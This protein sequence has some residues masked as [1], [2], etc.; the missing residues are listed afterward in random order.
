MLD[1]VEVEKRRSGVS[2]KKAYRPTG[3][4]LGLLQGAQRE[5]TN[6]MAPE[7]RGD[8]HPTRRRATPEKK[9]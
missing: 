8:F 5:E 6:R 9:A 3:R 2:P 7:K 4:P 1:E